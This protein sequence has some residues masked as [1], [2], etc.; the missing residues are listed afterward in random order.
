MVRRRSRWEENPDLSLWPY[1]QRGES[2]GLI[3][4]IPT[5]SASA[6]AYREEY[7]SLPNAPRVT[8]S[9]FLVRMTPSPPGSAG[10]QGEA[11]A[12]RARATLLGPRPCPTGPSPARTP[13]PPAPCPSA[14]RDLGAA[15]PDPGLPAGLG[16]A[17]ILASLRPCPARPRLP[18]GSTQ[19]QPCV[20]TGP[21]RPHPARPRPRPAGPHPVG[22]AAS[23]GKMAAWRRRRQPG[24][25]AGSAG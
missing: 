6:Q 11:V 7:G 17:D 4:L 13:T 14:A 21:A 8:G 15:P 10:G 1:F 24:L 20:C 5:A 18:P 22:P 23:S 12:V 3:F 2:L 16:P 25:E 9:H 19:T